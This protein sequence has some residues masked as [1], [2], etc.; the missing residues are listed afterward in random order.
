[1]KLSKVLFPIGGEGVLLKRRHLNLR[2]VLHKNAPDN[3]SVF[4]A[5]GSLAHTIQIETILFVSHHPR[6]LMQVKPLSLSQAFLCSNIRKCKCAF[7]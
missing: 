3:D 6:S 2:I 5:T 1:M 7:S 4:F